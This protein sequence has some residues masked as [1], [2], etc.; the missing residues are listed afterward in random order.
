M[1]PFQHPVVS[2]LPKVDKEISSSDKFPFLHSYNDS[3]FVADLESQYRFNQQKLYGLPSILKENNLV[4]PDTN[5]TFYRK[6][7]SYLLLAFS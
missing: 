7:G 4:Y 1:N 3:D 5:I 6:R 2:T